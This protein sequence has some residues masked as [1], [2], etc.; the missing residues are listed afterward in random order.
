MAG[1]DLLRECET[2]TGPC[3]LGGVEGHEQVRGICYAGTVVLHLKGKLLSCGGPPDGDGGA[4]RWCVLTQGGFHGVA[5]EVDQELF[6]LCGV[7]LQDGGWSWLD[8]DRNPGLQCN[9]AAEEV[10]QK[11]RLETW[12][13]Q[14]CE[15]LV[16]L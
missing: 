4:A 14:T 6:D 11:D 3:R 5:Y 12:A 10:E 7:D 13:R 9:D 15:L 16:S 1:C 8:P 2:D